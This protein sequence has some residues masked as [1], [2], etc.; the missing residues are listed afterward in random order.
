MTSSQTD[1]MAEE[2]E[3]YRKLNYHLKRIR[4]EKGLTQ[5]EVAVATGIP[6]YSIS[7]WE[8]GRKAP[9]FAGILRLAKFYGVSID[10]LLEEVPEETQT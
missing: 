6:Q 4:M 2:Q 10:E 9:M 3:I 1:R 8:I 7:D 5:T